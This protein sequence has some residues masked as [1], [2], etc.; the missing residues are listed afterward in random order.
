MAKNAFLKIFFE[1]K[2]IVAEI[3]LFVVGKICKNSN[4]KSLKINSDDVIDKIFK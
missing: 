4:L 2:P 3:I 1:L